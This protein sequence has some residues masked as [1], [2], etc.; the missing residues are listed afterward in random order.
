M[1]EALLDGQLY[2]F[3]VHEGHARFVRGFIMGIVLLCCIRI[4]FVN[5]GPLEEE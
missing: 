4:H 3:I 2:S 1:S 5:T